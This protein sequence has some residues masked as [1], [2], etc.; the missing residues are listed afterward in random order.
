MDTLAEANKDISSLPRIFAFVWI[1]N[2]DGERVKVS[3]SNVPSIAQ[4]KDIFSSKAHA[5]EEV[6]KI[7]VKEG[8]P[9][10][11]VIFDPKVSGYQELLT[12]EAI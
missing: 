8:I 3:H 12:L 1:E 4:L 6:M 11:R 7:A 5:R 2:I 10:E 9:E